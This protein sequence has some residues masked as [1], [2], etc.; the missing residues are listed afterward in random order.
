MNNNTDIIYKEGF[1]ESIKDLVTIPH[2]NSIVSDSI[3]SKQRKEYQ[4]KINR[5]HQ[6]IELEPDN[7]EHIERRGDLN[8]KMGRHDKALLD[9]LDANNLG[10]D[11]EVNIAKCLCA[12]GIIKEK[13]GF[14][15]DAL[16]DYVNNGG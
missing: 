5:L 3:T 1:R 11:D 6:M 13:A 9:Y 2:K 4:E 15:E 12:R 8:Y 16:E 10:Q 7:W 14:D